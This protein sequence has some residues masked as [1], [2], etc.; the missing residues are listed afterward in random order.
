MEIN[1]YNTIFQK[2]S[3]WSFLICKTDLAPS[4]FLKEFAD[5]QVS[6]LDNSNSYHK[7]LLS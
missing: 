1:T 6:F 4:L 7:P 3:K 2:L 5:L